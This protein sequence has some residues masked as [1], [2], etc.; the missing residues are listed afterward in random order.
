MKCDKCE[1]EFSS[2]LAFCPDCEQ[3][4]FG[5][6]LVYYAS[7]WIHVDNERLSVIPVSIDLAGPWDYTD[8]PV[9]QE[10]SVPTMPVTNV[11]G[12][13]SF[14]DATHVDAK[15]GGNFS[16]KREEEDGQ[17]SLGFS[18]LSK[19]DQGPREFVFVFNPPA[20][21]YPRVIE[22]GSEWVNEFRME[23]EFGIQMNKETHQVLANNSI[24]LPYGDLANCFLIRITSVNPDNADKLYRYTW[25]VPGIGYVASIISHQGESDSVFGV[26]EVMTRLKD[27]I[28]H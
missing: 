18:V 11:P 20:L 3:F 2:Q 8:G 22:V 21:L 15:G 7:D 4:R 1:S 17:Y 23:T 16:F 10:Q 25:Y 26:A 12:V 27:V 19:V 9:D 6:E 13:E 28:R 5:T 24:K 14:P